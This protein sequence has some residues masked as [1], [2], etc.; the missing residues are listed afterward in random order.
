MKQ[1]RRVIKYFWA[2]ARKRSWMFWC[3]LICYGIGALIART[4]IPIIYRNLIDLIVSADSPLSAKTEIYSLLGVLILSFI[5]LNI[6]FRI[7][8][9]VF[10]AF[11]SRSMRDLYSQ[12]FTLFQKHSFN[13]FSNTFSGSLIAKTKRYVS[14][15]EDVFDRFFYDFWFTFV[16]VV[17]AIVV[18]F[19]EAPNVG[20]V[21]L[22]GVSVF[23]VAVI[24]LSNKGRPLREIEARRDSETTGSFSDAISNIFAIKSF[25]NSER[26][27]KTFD[28]V[29][30]NQHKARI[31]AWNFDNKRIAIL[32]I[33]FFMME[34]GGMY[35]A[36]TLWMKGSITPGTVA[37]VQIYF[38]NIFYNIWNFGRAIQRFNKSIADSIEIVDIFEKP[39]DIEDAVNPERSRIET[40]NINFSNTSFRYPNGTSVFENLNLRIDAGQKIGLVG[41]SGAGKTTVTKLLL[42]FY[43]VSDG[44]ILIDGQNIRN[45]KQDDLRRAISYVP[46]EP[47]LFH[48]SIK[49]N[50][51]YGKEDAT[52][53]E[54]IDCAKRA[55]A[56]DFIMQLPMGYDTLVGE[57][58]VKLS[59]GERQRIVIARAMLKPAPILILD[60]ATSSLDSISESAIQEALDELMKGKTTIAIAHRLST[61]Q[62][63]DRIIVMHDGQIV[64]D[65]THTELIKKKGIY[66]E[67]WSHQTAGFIE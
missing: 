66:S 25:A 35:V 40:G 60:E 46:Q 26:E 44:E 1:I 54:I 43:D 23:I 53:E 18:L 63:M 31:R 52:L 15:F 58:G 2:I 12:A 41:H 36:I 59:G 64:E 10:A 45:I 32:G 56:H 8:D 20:W 17:G 24:S 29:L 37:L 33:I 13:F 28:H 6:F 51:S 3:T 34:V 65:G 11:Q 50:I 21:V 62:K 55:R 49:E 5:A 30:E 16:V 4:F 61:I 27:Q 39:I 47:L 9:Y 22:I 38:G 7:A 42:R 48:R 19:T 67:L 57:R 14:S